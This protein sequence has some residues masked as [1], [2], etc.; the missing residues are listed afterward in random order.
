MVGKDDMHNN[1][2]NDA[3]DDA[4]LF[5]REMAD[6]NRSHRNYREARNL[7]RETAPKPA[8]KIRKPELAAPVAGAGVMVDATGYGYG[9]AVLFAR[10]GLQKKIIQ[11]LKRGDY[12]FAE[13]LDLHGHTIAEAEPMLCDFLLDAIE[14]GNSPVLIIH[15]KGL[16]S[17][18]PG[19][20]LKPF[21]HDWLKQQAAVK[22][23]CSALP[24]DGGTGAVY[25]LLRVGGK[26]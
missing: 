20:V 9:D 23:F 1:Q 14:N 4:A 15:G 7:P 22:A 8:V 6:V 2:D 3:Q 19:G 11:K 18:E 16:R 10:T 25:V 12:G 21:T 26:R 13:I 17:F 5:R 24:K